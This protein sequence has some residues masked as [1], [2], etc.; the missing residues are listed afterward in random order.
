MQ[1]ELLNLKQDPHKKLPLTSVILKTIWIKGIF[2][3]L[4]G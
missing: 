4:Q 3:F 2:V 1:K